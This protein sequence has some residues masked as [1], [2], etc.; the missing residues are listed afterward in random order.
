MPVFACHAIERR[1]QS[2]ASSHRCCANTSK[3]ACLHF[4]ASKR[5]YVSG[6]KRSCIEKMGNTIFKYMTPI[7]SAGHRAYRAD[8]PR[9]R[10]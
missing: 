9:V 10:A 4:L 1:K 5:R 8:A 6:S 3:P 2:R 7:F